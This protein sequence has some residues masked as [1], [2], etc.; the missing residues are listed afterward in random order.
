MEQLMRTALVGTSL[1]ENEWR[2]PLH[3][4]H[5]STL[6]EAV[7]A[8]I[9][10]DEGYGAHFNVAD[11]EL[12]PFVAGILPR[13]RLLAEADLIVITKPM[14]Q[15]YDLMRPDTTFFGWVHAVSRSGTIQK[16]IDKR[17]TLIT[18]ESMN[19]WHPG[20]DWDM[21]IFNRN[22]EM[23]GYCGVVHCFGLMGV[24]GF[25]GPPMK[26]AVFGLGSAAH[27]AMFALSQRG[28][29]DIVA[30]G[31]ERPGLVPRRM[32]TV[33]YREVRRQEGGSLLVVDG[34]GCHPLIDDLRDRDVIFNGL[35]Q[36]PA[37]PVF[38]LTADD[39]QEMRPGTLVLDISSD[40][41][42]GFPFSRMTT[43]DESMFRAGPIDYYSVPHTPSYLFRA[44]SWEISTAVLPYLETV[45]RGPE[46][47]ETDETVR[48]A[49]EVRNGVVLN[50]TILESQHRASDYPH[51]LAADRPAPHDPEDEVEAPAGVSSV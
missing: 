2:L 30:Y 20:G 17:L 10:I 14:P 37:N 25:Y 12:R 4:A 41:G 26:A 45:M 7:R 29:R 44:S 5:F 9:Y 28:V 49:V 8:A 31:F 22:S 51:E 43:F 38:I 19:K 18:W 3:P 39:V 40:E 42:M 32:Q 48:R 47:W 36:D 46:A 1:R 11:D 35:L 6:P 16:A 13:E 27:G 23:A 50:K 24:D 34:G 15:D 33:E 21:H